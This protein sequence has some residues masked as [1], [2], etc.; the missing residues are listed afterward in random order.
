MHPRNALI[1]GGFALTLALVFFGPSAA[2]GFAELFA[3]PPDPAA[4]PVWPVA[5]TDPMPHSGDAADDP[6]IWVHPSRPELS[7]IIGTDKK[8]GLAVYDLSGRQIQYLAHGRMNNVDIRRGFPLGQESVDLVVTGNRSDNSVGIYRVNPTSRQL[9]NVAARV[10]TTIETYG[11]CMYRSASSGKYYYFVNS[12]KGDVQQ[13]ELFAD[14]SGKVDAREVR[15]FS[16]GGETEGCVADDELGSLYIAQEDVGIWKYSAEPDRGDTGRR[17]IDRTGEGGHLVADV[18]GLAIAY[19]AKGNG[20][21][22]ASSQGS[23]SYVLYRRGDTNEYVKS[24]KIVSHGGIDA[25]TET[26]GLDVTTANL[27]PAFPGGLFVAQDG[28]NDNG[29][30]NFKLVRWSAIV[31][32]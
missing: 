29:N 5:E 12:K 18:E 32:R 15:S 27:G 6:A 9:H 7:T 13:W 24:F 26:D 1:A 4:E 3:T 21:L 10:I 23:S 25:V 17:Q 19:Y 2:R 8:G 16:V 14:N 30:Q 28:S 31:R 22:V 20:Y 11:S